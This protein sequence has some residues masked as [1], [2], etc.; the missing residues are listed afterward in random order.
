MNV[1]A[2]L[3]ELRAA[4]GYDDQIV[5]YRRLPGRR[6]RTAELDPPLP[7][8]LAAALAAQGIERLYS[9]QVAAVQQARARQDQVIVTGT[10]SGKTLC[11]NLP[12]LERILAERRAR[13]LYL[14]P[15]KALAQDQLKKLEAFD[16]W[17]EVRCATY[18]G[19]TPE[20]QRRVARSVAHIILTNPDMLHV[21]VLPRH[22]LWGDFLANLEYI[23]VDEVHMYRGV[24]GSHTAHV[25]RRLLRICEQ[26]GR[27]PTFICSSATIAN[28]A[29][30]VEQLTGRAVSVIDEN[31]AP[32]GAK[33]LVVWNPPLQDQVSGLRR[34]GNIEATILLSE[35]IQRGVRVLGFARARQEAELILRYLRAA[36]EA[37]AP[38][39]IPRVAAYR[40]GYLATDRRRIEQQL[41]A[42]ELLAVVSTV[43]LEAGID[44]GGLDATVLIG[45]PGT[46]AGYQQQIG[47]A[48]R[49]KRDSLG[50]LV[51]RAS[52]I[53][54]YFAHHPE[55]LWSRPTE[56]AR[57]DPDNVYIL[58]SH[59]LC[60]AYE[61][62]LTD[63]DVDSFGPEA[64]ALLPIFESERFL[65][66][67]GE[68]WFYRSDEYPAAAVSLRS[69]GT[70]HFDL[71]DQTRAAVIGI[72]DASRLWEEC[73]PGAIHLHDGEQY[74]VET[75]D[76]AERRILLEP[77]E[78]NWFTSP[79]V[80]I[81]VAVDDATES[82]T[83]GVCGVG[84]G[85]LTVTKTTTGYRQ[86]HQ[87]SFELLA[88][89]DVV[90]PPRSMETT[91]L[92]LTVP[93][94]VERFIMTHGD[95][96]LAGL[97]GV[98]HALTAALPLL[99]MCDPRDIG[100][101]SVEFHPDLQRP[102][103]F[104]FD[105]YPGGIGL[106]ERG[107]ERIDE[108]LER[109]HAVVANCPCET[110]CP[111]CIQL[112]WCQRANH[113]LDKLLTQVLLRAATARPYEEEP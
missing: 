86:L 41:S 73:Y 62:P 77:V 48:G 45:Y 54:Q 96:L 35:L 95:Q 85:E 34:S 36:L 16:L 69:T 102:A 28:P 21:G 37:D 32:T 59:L 92:W 99:A 52:L 79:L 110:G 57:I 70:V 42:G 88:V 106:T 47:R 55:T 61:A 101:T 60:A 11:Y 20:D 53:D 40:A 43:A 15:L 74:R 10:A 1:A 108:L 19:D 44:I 64:P 97:H 13:A 2:F 26:Y 107:F 23:I 12:V 81:D 46:V 8:K 67:R 76:E 58:G 24:F 29:E 63:S 56:E 65:E 49:G 113:P 75:V 78:V 17:R 39:L 112:P 87:T 5:A 27:R 51:T 66:R 3:D 84:F 103:L 50:V 82:A 90:C 80:Q 72:E 98:E 9:H 83:A 4:P 31:G 109:A 18:D 71:V 33:H 38:A 100:G 111:A 89:H 93:P 104:I 91:G 25:L 6:A 68:R 22:T 105:Q 14:F 30:L 7:D 94:E